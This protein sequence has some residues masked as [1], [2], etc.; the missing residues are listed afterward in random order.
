MNIIQ[1][2][3]PIADKSEEVEFLYQNIQEAFRHLLKSD[4]NIIMIDFNAK[5]W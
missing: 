3:S 1:I 4:L 5:L 2:Y